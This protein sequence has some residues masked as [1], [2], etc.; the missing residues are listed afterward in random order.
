MRRKNVM[1]AVPT[2]DYQRLLKVA[3]REERLPNQQALVMLRKAL[4]GDA[5]PAEQAAAYG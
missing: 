5:M 2:E 3:E 1:L 4:Q